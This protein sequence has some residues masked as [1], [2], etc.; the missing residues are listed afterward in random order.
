MHEAEDLFSIIRHQKDNNDLYSTVDAMSDMHVTKCGKPLTRFETRKL[1][2]IQSQPILGYGESF[3]RDRLLSKGSSWLPDLYSIYSSTVNLLPSNLLMAKSTSSQAWLCIVVYR[4][5]LDNKARNHLAFKNNIVKWPSKA[6]SSKDHQCSLRKKRELRQPKT[7]TASDTPE[8]NAV[9]K[10][11]RTL[12]SR[13]ARTMLSAAKE[14]SVLRADSNCKQ[15]C[16][17]QNQSS[18]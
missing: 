6:E 1:K 10:T 16:F 11:N 18:L 5:K 2:K 14:F 8:Q 13:Q 12:A 3:K 17:T 7:S 4:I 9:R 15:Q